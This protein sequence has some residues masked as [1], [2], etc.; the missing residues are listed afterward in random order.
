VEAE[1]DKVIKSAIFKRKLEDEF[2]IKRYVIYKTALGRKGIKYYNMQDFSDKEVERL[3]RLLDDK[4]TIFPVVIIVV[5]LKIKLIF[6]V[7][8][9]LKRK[10][11]DDVSTLA[12][13]K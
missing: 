12:F 13:I 6:I 8:L 10:A 9:K 1:V 11:I 5:I 7:F 4:H 2:I 3:S